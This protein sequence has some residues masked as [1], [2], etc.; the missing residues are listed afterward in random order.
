M[1]ENAKKKGFSGSAY[2]IFLEYDVYLFRSFDG[3]T[4]IY[5]LRKKITVAIVSSVSN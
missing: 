3:V 5:T 4:V 1:I 2:G